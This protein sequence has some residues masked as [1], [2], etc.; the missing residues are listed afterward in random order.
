M[1]VASG[2]GQTN[3]LSLA[4]AICASEL[5]CCYSRFNDPDLLSPRGTVSGGTSEGDRLNT[6]IKTLL[7]RKYWG[8]SINTYSNCQAALVIRELFICELAYS[9]WQKWQ[10]SVK[11]SLFICEFKIRGPKWRNVSTANYEGNL[12]FNYITRNNKILSTL[13]MW[14]INRILLKFTCTYR[15]TKGNR[16]IVRDKTKK[17]L[18]VR[19]NCK[20]FKEKKIRVKMRWLRLP[21]ICNKYSITKP[22]LNG[23]WL[24]N[25]LETSLDG[26]ETVSWILNF[27]VGRFEFI[28]QPE[29]DKKWPLRRKGHFDA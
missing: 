27:I 29:N 19:V 2:S 1:V 13:G 3:E 17:R 20:P 28:F 25:L 18:Y 26:L 9:H 11:N 23:A 16:R 10:F 22:S 6:F 14:S 7:C 21:L 5:A 12:Y 15:Y 8:A 24:K 4:D